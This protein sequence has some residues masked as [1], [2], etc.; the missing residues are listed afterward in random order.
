MDFYISMGASLLLTALKSIIHDT[1]AKAKFESVMLKIAS[2]IEAAY[3][4][5]VV[6]V[7]ANKVSQG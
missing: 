1:A 6:S 5:D 2:A 4:S 7:N 3:G